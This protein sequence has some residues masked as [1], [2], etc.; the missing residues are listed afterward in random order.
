MGAIQAAGCSWPWGEPD[1]DWRSL[2]DR[3]VEHV[4][5]CEGCDYVTEADRQFGGV[6]F[7]DSEWAVLEAMADSKRF[8]G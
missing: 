7:S 4:G 5:R 2:L 1:I 8:H 6:T 3:C